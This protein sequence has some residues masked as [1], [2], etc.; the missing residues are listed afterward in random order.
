MWWRWRGG[1]SK[2]MQQMHLRLEALWH[3]RDMVS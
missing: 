3:L 2:W 1:N